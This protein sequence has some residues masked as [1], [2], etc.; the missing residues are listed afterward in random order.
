MK[1]IALITLWGVLTFIS[2]GCSEVD[3]YIKKAV[4]TAAE[5]NDTQLERSKWF[6][7]YGASVGSVRRN[8]ETPEKAELWRDFCDAQYD[9]FVPTKQ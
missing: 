3:P 5:L 2:T 9:V 4:D 8:Y 7:C 1:K 6:I